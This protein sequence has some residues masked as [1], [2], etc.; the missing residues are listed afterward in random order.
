M[1][2]SVLEPLTIPTPDDARHIA[3]LHERLLH[4]ATEHD[5]VDVTYRTVD[6][7]IGPLLLAA[8]PAGVVR[9]AFASEGHDAVLDTLA[10]RV[11][12]RILHDPDGF[13]QLVHELGEYFAGHRRGFEV[14][15]DLRLA[16]GF[17]REVLGR[18]REIPYGSTSS[19]AA[20]AASAGNPRAV[21]AVGSACA[22]NPIPIVV[23]CHRV[24]R[25]DGTPGG[26]LGGPETKAF[27]LRLESSAA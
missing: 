21:R 27:L 16:Q 17:R 25:S 3:R 22:T 1:P 18:L 14:P 6:T 24:V 11:G 2:D 8:T 5:L 20:V 13:A 9:V 4:T 15:V 26:Y 12:P 10:A 19:Y 7:P 23:P